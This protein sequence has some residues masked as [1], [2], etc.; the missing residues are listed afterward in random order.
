[1]NTTGIDGKIVD[2]CCSAANIVVLTETNKI[3]YSGL[4]IAS[5]HNMANHTFVQL[6]ISKKIIKIGMTATHLITLSDDHTVTTYTLGMDKTTTKT[7][8]KESI[9]DF[10]YNAKEYYLMEEIPPHK[11]WDTSTSIGGFETEIG[12]W[13]E[14]NEFHIQDGQN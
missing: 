9:I 3:Y 13:T 1:M 4:R 14:N 7:I 11:F 12:Y 10:A 5:N 8:Q 2:V 6:P